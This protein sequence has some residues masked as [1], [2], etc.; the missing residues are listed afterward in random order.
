MCLLIQH[1]KWHKS[2][3]VS[4]IFS[5][6]FSFFYW[7]L[8]N[9]TYSLIP[10]HK[11]GLLFPNFDNLTIQTILETALR[12]L[13]INVFLKVRQIILHI[14]IFFYKLWG[15]LNYNF[16]FFIKKHPRVKS[17]P[18][19]LRQDADRVLN[20]MDVTPG[21]PTNSNGVGTFIYESKNTF[22]IT[23]FSFVLLFFL[24]DI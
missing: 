2:S 22:I 3:V 17:C 15:A 16:F 11:R 8:L 21:E 1:P 12:T 5:L 14:N 10:G 24:I 18:L 4:L 6:F 20:T 13:N 23:V 9:I 7:T 19:F